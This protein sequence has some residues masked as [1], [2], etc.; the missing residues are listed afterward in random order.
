[1]Q[2]K[3]NMVPVVCIWEAWHLI[4]SAVVKWHPESSSGWHSLGGWLREWPWWVFASSSYKSSRVLSKWT[5]SC[6]AWLRPRGH[7]INVGG[8]L[9][10]VGFE[11]PNICSCFYPPLVSPQPQ[12]S[13]P[14][15]ELGRDILCLCAAF[16]GPSCF[17]TSS[18]H[19]SPGGGDGG[20]VVAVACP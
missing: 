4:C 3:L 17:M 19:C 13:R 7:F 9:T 1:M 12:R 10:S 11:A 2:K 5:H 20:R 18:S 14:G 16:L 15:G 6:R 8:N